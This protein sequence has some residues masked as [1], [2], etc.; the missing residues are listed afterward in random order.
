[1]EFDVFDLTDFYE[2]IK[3]HYPNIIKEYNDKKGEDIW[4]KNMI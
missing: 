2:W 4:M 3:V 1:M